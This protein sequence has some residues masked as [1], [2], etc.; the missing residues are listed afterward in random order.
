MIYGL[1]EHRD[2]TELYAFTSGAAPIQSLPTLSKF[3]WNMTINQYTVF[4]E[5]IRVVGT[6]LLAVL[7][8]SVSVVMKK[9]VNTMA[10]VLGMT[11]L[12]HVLNGFGLPFAKNF[13][14]TAVLSGHE[15]VCM[16]LESNLYCVL[17][18]GIILIGIVVGIYLARREWLRK[19]GRA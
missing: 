13:D 2:L 18:T 3:P 5:I 7:T 15:Y 19:G 17:F 9:H 4:Y 16:S 14:F 1:M 12:P 10:V 8:A 6:V 11:M